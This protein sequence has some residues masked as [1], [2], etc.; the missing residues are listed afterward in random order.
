MISEYLIKKALHSD[1]DFDSA[2]DFALEQQRLDPNTGA[3][4]RQEI[5]NEQ[6]RR[7]HLG[8]PSGVRTGAMTGGTLSQYLSGKRPTPSR[9]Q[10]AIGS[11]KYYP[12]QHTQPAQHEWA[13]QLDSSMLPQ[14]PPPYNGLA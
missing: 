2:S 11:E 13:H 7:S 9:P 10:G 4:R 14:T 3:S 8:I 12:P 1:S 5:I 6:K